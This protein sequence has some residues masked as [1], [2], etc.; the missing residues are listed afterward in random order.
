MVELSAAL[1]NGDAL[2]T[3]GVLLL[4]VVLFIS[5]AIAPELTGF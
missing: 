5:G 1:Q 3:L 2:V 4:A